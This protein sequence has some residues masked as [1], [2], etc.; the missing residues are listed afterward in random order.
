MK[1]L[2]RGDG[3]IYHTEIKLFQYLKCKIKLTKNI[4]INIY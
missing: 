2:T 3:E 1:I 4:D